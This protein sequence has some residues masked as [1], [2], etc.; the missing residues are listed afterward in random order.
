MDQFAKP[1]LVFGLAAAIGLAQNTGTTGSTD[2][3]RRPGASAPDSHDRHGA[4]ASDTMRGAGSGMGSL[5]SSEK[6][7]MMKAAEGGAMEV[8]VAQMA[9]QKASSSEVKEYARQLE[10]DH[11]K[12]NNQLRAIAKQKNVDLPEHTGDVTGSGMSQL[13][14][15]SGSQFDQAFMRMQVQ[16]H[17]K[18][19][20]EFQK[21][22]KSGKDT[23]LKRFAQQTL[24]T[25][26]QHLD[27]AQRISAGTGGRGASSG[28]AD[29]S[30]STGTMGRDASGNSSD[31]T[32]GNSSDRT[33]SSNDPKGPQR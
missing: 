10:Q 31:R 24:P 15:L 2:T 26:Q 14:N 4:T 1:L 5:A 29:R 20:S 19:I 17:K 16:H 30:G 21:Q 8:K 28:S 3:Q 33:G 25:L 13:Q 22:A 32:G 27:Q 9:Q 12:A 23:D 11:Q 18:D 6:Q 7:F